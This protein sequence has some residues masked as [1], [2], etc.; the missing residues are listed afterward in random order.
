MSNKMI[1]PLTLAIGAAFVGA[2]SLASVAQ[3][4]NSFQLSQMNN[5]YM[6]GD[7]A[8]EGK[9]ERFDHFVRHAHVLHRLEKRDDSRRC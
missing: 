8:A 5:G 9:S 4:S 7:K 6:L 2:V 1:K 3:A